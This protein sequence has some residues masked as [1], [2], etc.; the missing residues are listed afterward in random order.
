MATEFELSIDVEELKKSVGGVAND[1]KAVFK[2]KIVYSDYAL[3]KFVMQFIRSKIPQKKP[4]ISR[5]WTKQKPAYIETF[6]GFR[7]DKTPKEFMKG[8][9]QVVLDNGR[10]Y[11]GIGNRGFAP[12]E[13]SPPYRFS[14]KVSSPGNMPIDR[15]SGNTVKKS[16][17][18]KVVSPGHVIIYA[19]PDRLNI[20]YKKK[21]FDGSVLE[22]DMNVLEYGGQYTWARKY[23][24]GYRV[25][26]RL[27]HEARRGSGKTLSLGKKVNK[28]GRTRADHNVRY[29]KPRVAGYPVFEWKSGIADMK[30]RPMLRLG[31]R[32]FFRNQYPEIWKDIAE[33]QLSLFDDVS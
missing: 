15:R 6:A 5:V 31:I 28:S 33:V 30:S 20:D 13:N 21:G 3:G 2:K 32:A 23:I 24:A 29:K 18:F 22:P 7:I 8:K 16:V 9:R 4:G 27:G 1:I 12:I 17:F 11:R 26:T 19:D 25:E 14:E 10:S